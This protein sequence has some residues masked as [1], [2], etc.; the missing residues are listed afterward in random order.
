MTPEQIAKFESRTTQEQRDKAKEAFSNLPAESAAAFKGSVQAIKDSTQTIADAR[1]QFHAG[2][3]KP[4]NFK[5]TP[6]KKAEVVLVDRPFDH[7]ANT[8]MANDAIA[9]MNTAR[10][11][12]KESDE[13]L[14]NLR[15]SRLG[16]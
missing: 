5:N 9:G 4:I 3:R 7:A 6:S 13:K 14:R 10:A 12:A 15:S 8:K 11:Q 16:Q 1:E 2:T